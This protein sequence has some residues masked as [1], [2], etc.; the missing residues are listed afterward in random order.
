MNICHMCNGEPLPFYEVSP[1]M[2]AHIAEVH[3][4]LRCNKCSRIFEDVSELSELG[5]CCKV[6]QSP[7]FAL[8]L[9]EIREESFSS[10]VEDKNKIIIENATPLTQINQ[11]WRRKSREF[12]KNDYEKVEPGT[13]ARQTS[14]P[15]QLSSIAANFTDSSSYNGSS[16]QISSINCV[17]SCSSES[18]EFSPPLAP[19]K[20]KT[21]AVPLSPKVNRSRPKL[22]VQATPLRQVMSKSIQRAIAEHGHYR[23][24]AVQ[25]QQ[26]KMSFNSTNSSSEGTMSFM[27]LPSG[28]DSPL[29]LRMSP[30]LRRINE[31]TKENKLEYLPDPID[32]INFD[33]ELF[34]S[35]KSLLEIEHFK[36][37]IR[38]SEIK[39]D[40]SAMTSY[41]SV[42]SDSGRSGSMPEIQF[43]PK[44]VGN[45]FNKKTIS[46]ESP[47][48]EKT[49]G[50][51]MPI[52]DDGDEDVF[53]TPRASPAKTSFF[54][55][56]STDTI[57]P[58]EDD[59]EPTSNNNSKSKTIWNLVSL[60]G[61]N[62]KKFKKPE[63]VKRAADYFSKRS[64]EP[65]EFPY[66]R[67]RSSTSSNEFN[68]GV[69]P[70]K[71]QK[72]QG[73]KPIS[74]L[75]QMSLN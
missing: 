17:S 51:L 8:K 65:D 26:R 14:T 2:L 10:P 66:K 50:C 19:P 74:R 44:I 13:V 9:S 28:N 3:F 32:L 61:D 70:A 49:P 15:M 68:L 62:L 59:V 52:E 47:D 75:R 64:S 43:T 46:F 5:K 11:R 41:K 29:D 37:V 71:R 24:S 33:S 6:A 48:M 36:V 34:E 53:Y 57:I 58:I 23:N 45:N 55:H 39:S 63:F 42:F 72:I 73:R 1:E 21:V 18:D 67:R 60:F 7:E 4:P 69:T 38:R 30:A 31:E 56:A 27:K 16:I 35:Q 22:P 12:G 54:R 25:I 40:S 20:T